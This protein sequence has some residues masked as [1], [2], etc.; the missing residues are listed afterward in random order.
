MTPAFHPLDNAC[1][2]SL[3][4]PR[5]GYTLPVFACAA[6]IAALRQLNAITATTDSGIDSEADVGTDEK[7]DSTI[8]LRTVP[9][10]LINPDH[11]VEIEI[12]HYAPLDENRALA[13]T[14]SDPGD[15][16]DLTRHTPVW[17]MVTRRPFDASCERIHIVGGEG[18]GTQVQ[19]GR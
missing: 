3:P 6:A 18:I 1:D 5:A 13:I 11:T 14:R 15:N 8:S 12:E 10:F 19:T 2:P 17:A 4:Q 7:A 9:V 16:L